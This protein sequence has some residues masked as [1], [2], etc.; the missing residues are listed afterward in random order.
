[1]GGNSSQI[2]IGGYQPSI[3]EVDGGYSVH[4][5]GNFGY[6]IVFRDNAH[7]NSVFNTR[8]GIGIGMT[9]ADSVPLPNRKGGIFV[10]W[11]TA[12]TTIGGPA[13]APITGLRYA[14][15]IVGNYGNGITAVFAKGLQLLG[16]TVSGNRDSGVFL[17]GADSAIIGVPFAGDIITDNGRYGLFATGD[18]GSSTIQAATIL[19]NGASGVRLTW[20]QNIAVGGADASEF[21]NISN[22][23]GWGILANGW[24]GGSAVLGNITDNNARGGVNTTFAWGLRTGAA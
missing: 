14:D 20:A 3:E 10:G 2:A 8:V 4:V 1:M 24:S 21:N 11:G 17:A 9:I 13:L 15:Q 18:L 23:Q 16:N 22:N 12:N 19:G 6:G 7:D 5:G